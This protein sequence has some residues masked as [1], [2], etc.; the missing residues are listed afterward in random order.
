MLNTLIPRD[1]CPVHWEI[2]RSWRDNHYSPWNPREWPGGSHIMDS[3]TSHSERSADWD[4]KNLQQ[5][6]LT[7]ACCRSGRSPQCTPGHHSP[8]SAKEQTV[9]DTTMPA[10]EQDTYVPE[11]G[12]ERWDLRLARTV[13]AD[14]ALPAFDE[15]ASGAGYSLGPDG[16]RVCAVWNQGGRRSLP[17]AGTAARALWDDALEQI[18]SVLTRSPAFADVRRNRY[19]VSAQVVLP[20]T[21]QAT[22][23]MRRVGVLDK[24]R[25][26][27]RFDNYPTAAGMLTLA[28]SGASPESFWI[29]TDAAG[30][31]VGRTN[32]GYQAAAELLAHHYGLPMP[33]ALVDE[34]RAR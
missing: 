32:G 15:N 33:L 19:R 23:R 10:P 14:T 29:V 22:A 34:G 27:V 1:V 5:L 16:W 7:V 18:E 30:R 31:E 25:R 12:A 17:R 4:R 9:P 13:I 24:F 8:A 3:R 11:P 20:Q 2:A 6:E 28:T 26:A 21:P